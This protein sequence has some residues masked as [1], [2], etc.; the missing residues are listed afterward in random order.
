MKK[1]L[2]VF[3]FLLSV[4]FLFN[5]ASAQLTGGGGGTLNV[6]N[7]TGCVIWVQGS[8][9]DA[10]CVTTCQSA[11]TNINPNTNVSIPFAC[12]NI[13]AFAASSTIIVGIRDIA[14]NVGFKI[15]NGCG[16]NFT[17]TYVDCQGISRTATFIAPNTVLVQ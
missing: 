4:G 14:A 2:F 9:L 17:G 16:V 15:G 12:L 1:Y 13:D 8:T 5:L 7:N 3:S 11:G 6:R 10:N